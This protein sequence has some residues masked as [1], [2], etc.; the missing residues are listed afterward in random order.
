MKSVN[1]YNISLVL[2]L[3]YIGGSWHTTSPG[4]PPQTA[5]RHLK[6]Y[7]DIPGSPDV[8]VSLGR[9]ATLRCKT[10]NL[11]KKS[12][13]WLRRKDVK[14]LSVGTY[15]YTTDSRLAV[16]QDLSGGE[17]QLVIRDVAFSDAG[18]YECQV[19]TSPV[20][21]HTI[22]LAVVEPYTKILLD[23]SA[24][25]GSLYIDI[26]SV[27]NLTC[28]VFSPEIPA[29]I[30]W[31]H[32]GKLLDLGGELEGNIQ[33]VEGR[34]GSPTLSL[35]SLVLTRTDQSGLYTCSPSNTAHTE[36]TVHIVQD[37]EL[38][39][40]QSQSGAPER[41]AEQENVRARTTSPSQGDQPKGSALLVLG[42]L[43]LARL[44]LGETA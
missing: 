15:L 34:A 5:G 39:V 40:G 1:F 29:A 3:Y 43:L 38:P 32:N 11:I 19:N 17:W 33:T 25:D 16:R 37:K 2:L 12:V 41:T 18:E 31:K 21:S 20:L 28:A 13:S 9:T 26:R 14:L 22:S 10:V 23:N 8:N 30:F 24:D 7:I 42:L 35:L 36:V 4:K 44:A 27:L 6:P